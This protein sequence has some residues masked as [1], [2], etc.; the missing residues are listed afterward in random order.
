LKAKSADSA[1]RRRVPGGGFQF[2]KPRLHLIE[3]ATLRARDVE[4][5]LI[6]HKLRECRAYLFR[7]SCY[8]NQR[9]FYEG[10]G[11]VAARWAGLRIRAL[12]ISA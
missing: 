4:L 6:A 10:N 8:S 2:G 12:S 3:S 7:F 1:Q 11:L 9:A 5:L